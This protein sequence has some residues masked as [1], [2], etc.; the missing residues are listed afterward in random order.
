MSFAAAAVALTAAGCG[1]SST[2]HQSA[3][4]AS[5][6]GVYGAAPGTTV[7][8]APAAAADIKVGTTSLGSILSDGQGL[9][10]YLFEKDLSTTSTCSGAC[11]SAWPP[12]TT[13]ASQPMV[14]GNANQALLGTTMRPDG[15]TQLTYAGHP[16]YRFVGDH[17]PGDTTGQ[18]LHAFGAG[19][20]VLTPAGQKIEGGK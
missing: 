8:L 6:G 11:A 7:A 20:D 2:T 17:K 13:S 19:W 12:V 9:T 10:V 5:S 15:T 18:G 4:A 3:P 1:S 16:L 14:S